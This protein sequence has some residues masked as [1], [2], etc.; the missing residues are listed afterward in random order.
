M[1]S[2]LNAEEVAAYLVEHPDL[3]ETHP[4]LQDLP[5]RQKNKKTSLTDQRINRLEKKN[6]TLR[7]QVDRLLQTAHANNALLEKTQKLSLLL[8]EALD[9]NAQV[10]TLKALLEQDFNAD[11][12][13]LVL[14]DLSPSLQ[15]DFVLTPSL[16]DAKKKVAGLMNLQQI[17][18]GQLR[19]TEYTFLFP[20]QQQAPGSVIIIPIGKD[21]LRGLLAL[22]SHDKKRFH[23]KLDTFFAQYI[24]KI[25]SCCLAN[26]L[27][28]RLQNNQNDNP[29]RFPDIG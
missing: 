28:L 19:D 9:F 29:N 21:Q 2:P 17:F 5:Q 27:G 4:S 20:T 25:V 22:G 11:Y 10:A 18:C 26:T 1:S 12:Y 15:H 23:H 8:S 7:T 6:N 3:L 14:F 16:K 24:G 13:S